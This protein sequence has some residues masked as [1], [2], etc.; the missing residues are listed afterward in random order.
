MKLSEWARRHG[1]GKANCSNHILR[2]VS[3]EVRLVEIGCGGGTTTTR[4]LKREAVVNP[5]KG[6]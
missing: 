5:Q 2:G 6:S 1:L 3:R 4:S